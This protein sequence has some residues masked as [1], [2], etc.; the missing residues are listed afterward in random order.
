M[1]SLPGEVDNVGKTV[2]CVPTKKVSNGRFK[3]TV[4]TYLPTKTNGLVRGRESR[5]SGRVLSIK[6]VVE[7]RLYRF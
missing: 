5:D 6:R 3:D 4:L 2:R 1:T 7:I